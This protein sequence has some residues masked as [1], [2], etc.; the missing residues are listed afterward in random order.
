MYI[1]IIIYTFCKS[2]NQVLGK[3]RYRPVFG[4]RVNE[5]IR[6]IETLYFNDVYS[7][8]NPNEAFNIFYSKI[9]NFYTTTFPV[10]NKKIKRSNYSYPWMNGRL[11]KM[12]KNKFLLSNQL[13]R[14]FISK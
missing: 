2:F 4:D 3:I 7:T 13:K 8:D 14:G 1:W 6:K 9:F 12:Y 5:F 11:K 10:R